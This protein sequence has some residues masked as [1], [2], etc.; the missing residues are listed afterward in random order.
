MDCCSNP[1]CECPPGQCHCTPDHC[2]CDMRGLLQFTL[3]WELSLEEAT[4]QELA[5]KVE[6]RRGYHPSPGTLYPALKALAERGLV[7]LEKEGRTTR[8]RLTAQG[9]RGLE[10]SALYFVRAFGDIF[11]R[12]R[13]LGD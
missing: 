13:P 7:E 6:R 10:E 9:E 11:E 4:G 5:V 3:L 2:C 1:L 12:Y 8:Y